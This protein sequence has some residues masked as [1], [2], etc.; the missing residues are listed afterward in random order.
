MHMMILSLC[1]GTPVL[2]IA[3]EFKTR[4]LAA[5]LGIADVLLDIDTITADA[6]AASLERFTQD[7]DALRR[8]S[9]EAALRENASALSSAALFAHAVHR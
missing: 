3:Y 6:A 5:R 1:V 9:L 4:E 2:P 7:L 8:V